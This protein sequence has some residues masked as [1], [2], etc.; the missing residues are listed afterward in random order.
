MIEFLA[1]DWP[2]AGNV[3]ALTTTRRGPGHSQ[4]PF[5]HFNLGLQ[6]G[7]DPAAVAANR[8]MLRQQAQLP[9]EPHWLRQVHG[10][11]VHRV[12]HHLPQG[13]PIEADAAVT[14]VPGAVLAIL[15]ADCLPV[16]FAARDGSEIAAA[17]AGW[18]G[19]AAGVLE[20]TVAAMQSAPEHL[21]AWLGPAAGPLHYEIDTPVHTAFVE[22]D[23]DASDC[24]AATCP[25]HYRMDMYAVARRRLRACGVSTIH[26][27]QFCTIA[28]AGRFYSYRRDG[29]TGR[30]A[31]LIWMRD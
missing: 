19:L 11:G 5:E 29:V 9:N 7:D 14:R 24:F 4:A 10:I 27:G 13:E 26:G 25:G 12:Q 30:L 28:E 6:C 1:P 2:A 16:L 3:L 21:M 8:L 17:H 18:R 31:T 22:S 15:T 23:P 20:A